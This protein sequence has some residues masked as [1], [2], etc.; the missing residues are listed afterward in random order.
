ML[1]IEWSDA[2]HD[3]I[4]RAKRGW[5]RARRD[6]NLLSRRA[7]NSGERLMLLAGFAQM[8]LIFHSSQE[9]N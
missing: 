5:L 6:A 3:V 9:N 2:L 7:V 4:N 1:L 8:C